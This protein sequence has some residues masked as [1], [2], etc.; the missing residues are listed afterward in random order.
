[1]LKYRFLD[2]KTKKYPDEALYIF[3]E[4]KPPTNKH[5]QLMMQQI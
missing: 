5:S 2:E 4:N 3:V 1:M